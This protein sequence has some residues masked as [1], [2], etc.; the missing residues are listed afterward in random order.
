M[1][2]N[3][4]NRAATALAV[5]MILGASLCR[6]SLA[7][8]ASDVAGPGIVR[9]AQSGPWSVPATWEGGRIPAAGA[10]VQTR[11]GHTVTYDL[12]STDVF[13]SI[14]IAGVLSFA[15]DLDTRL[16]VG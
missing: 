16:D 10:R 11:A 12:K 3:R 6:S 8:G 1:I 7:S 2:S 15:R 13:R 5:T 14:H 4:M 9:T